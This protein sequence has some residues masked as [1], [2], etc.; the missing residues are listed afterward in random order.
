[1]NRR[2]CSGALAGGLFC[3]FIPVPFQ[4]LLAAVAAVAFRVNILIAVPTVWISNPITMPPIFYFCYLVG[5]AVLKTPAQDFNFELSYEWLLSGLLHIW[6]PFLLGCFLVGS[7][8]AITALALTRVLWRLHIIS[9]IKAKR[10]R[11][12]ERK[13][14]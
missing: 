4:M 9:Y 5:A 8:A 12:R 13:G 2:S 10:E 3:A 6:Q 11:R 14:S 1:M 7:I